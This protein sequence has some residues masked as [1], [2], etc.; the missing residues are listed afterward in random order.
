MEVNESEADIQTRQHVGP[1]CSRSEYERLRV[2][3]AISL[4]LRPFAH[5]VLDLDEVALKVRLLT[6]MLNE[7]KPIRERVQQVHDVLRLAS[8]VRGLE[9]RAMSVWLA[10]TQAWQYRR[11]PD[12]DYAQ[13]TQFVNCLPADERRDLLRVLID[14]ALGMMPKVVSVLLFG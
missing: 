7:Q 2:C 9:L 3:H 6:V 1:T 14:S 8:T 5:Q 12:R 13:F 4:L 10:V 11:G